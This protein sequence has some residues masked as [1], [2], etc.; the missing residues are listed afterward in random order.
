MLAHPL[1]LACAAGLGPRLWTTFPDAEVARL[2]GADRGQELPLA[3]VGLGPGEPAIRPGGDA[4]PGTIDADPVAFPLITSVHHAGDGTRLGEPV[5]MGSPL[6][7]PPPSDHLDAVILGRGSARRLDGAASLT[8]PQLETCLAL[9]LH[10]SR[11]TH[12]VAV[13]GVD[14]MRPG[15][16]RWPDLD[17]PVRSGSL[18]D[19]LWVVC[20]EQDL[21]RDAAV[22]VASAVDLDAIDDR[23]YREAQIDAGIAS[24]R[25]QLAATALGFGATAMSFVDPELVALVGAPLAGLLLT[26]LGVAPLR[27]KR[28]GTPRHPRDVSER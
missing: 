16:Y 24:G 2:V 27:T 12:F 23:G 5:P 14:G 4:E 25:L 20:W 17:E 22:V 18:R 28:A 6:A 9:G 19:E 10:G 15:V 26:C 8:W 21:C 7:D 13:S 11:V 1:L 3:V